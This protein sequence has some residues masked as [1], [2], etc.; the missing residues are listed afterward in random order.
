ASAFTADPKLADDLQAAHRYSGACTAALAAAGKG[1]DAGSL[2]D[3]ERSRLRQQALDWLR[4]DLAAFTRDAAI[5]AARPT[6][7]Q[8]LAHWQQDTNLTALRDAKALAAL[9][10]KER[11]AWQQFWADVAALHTKVETKK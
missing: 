10:A 9:P 8:R 3:N 11:A 7:Q 5:P 6:I 2:D 1:Q 4:A